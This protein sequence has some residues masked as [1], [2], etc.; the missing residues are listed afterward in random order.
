MLIKDEKFFML[1]IFLAIL[2]ILT[3]LSL[4]FSVLHVPFDKKLLRLFLYF[5]IK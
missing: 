5:P 3:P 2:S 1:S 4:I